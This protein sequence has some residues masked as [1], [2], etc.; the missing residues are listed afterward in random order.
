VYQDYSQALAK[1]YSAKLRRILEYITLAEQLQI[2]SDKI[3]GQIKKMVKEETE[4]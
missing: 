3:V 4:Y 1:E 2:D